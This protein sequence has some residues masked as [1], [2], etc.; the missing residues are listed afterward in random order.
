[1]MDTMLGSNDAAPFRVPQYGSITTETEFSGDNIPQFWQA[2]DNLTNPT[3]IAQGRFFGSTGVKPDKVQFTSWSRV[4]NTYWGYTVRP[5]YSNGDSAVSVIWDEKPLAPGESREYVT[6]Y[7]L[8]DFSE[9]LSLPLALSVYSDS[10]ISA[11]GGKYIPDPV[12]VKAY[13]QNVSGNTA[14]DVSVR[15][16]L[17]EG[18]KLADGSEEVQYIGTMAAG[19]LQ[20]AD[21]KVK[22]Q[23][24]STAKTY[25]YN[26]VLT[27]ADGYTKKVSRMLYV[28]A[29]QRS[30][31]IY[32]YT[33]FS[34][35]Q[36][37]DLTLNGWKS[38]FKGG[39]YSGRNFV[40]N[41]SEFYLDGKA[42]AAGTVTANGWKVNI[43]ERNENIEAIAMPELEEEILSKAGDC[44]YYSESPSF[45]QDTNIINGS[46]M[47][48]GDVTISGTNFEG[49][50]YIIADRDITYNVNNLNTTGRLVLYSR[51]GNITVNGTNIN[52]NGIMYAP[53]GKVS[54]NAN[55]T[56]VNGRI[57][58]DTVNFSGSIFNIKGSES[59][60][61]LI[62][63]VNQRGITKTYTASEDFSEGTLNGVSLAVP[64]QIILSESAAAERI[65]EEKVFGD[66]QS[67]NGI[68]VT[69]SADTSAISQN[70]E[71]VNISYGISGFGEIQ[72]DENAVDLIIV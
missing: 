55:E 34:A 65:P 20:Q 7:G 52:I 26:V 22:V 39:I 11:A 1:M 64:D 8:S 43:P 57:W 62:G 29:I 15:I 53:N 31:K 5:E 40:C 41:L 51:N 16:E 12:D 70:G 27:A 32:E 23:P 63:E 18:L 72:N 25:T 60:L 48:S 54:F 28:P 4:R 33:V 17:P 30:E 42:D 47:V 19:K 46:I 59:D 66:S 36:N 50:C 14:E 56:T 69:Y 3:V 2:F 35:S 37:E 38:D 13:V 67:G 6:Y 61:D 21:W 9:D 49:D 44:T 45:I 58:G 24:V 10:T 68:K 71:T